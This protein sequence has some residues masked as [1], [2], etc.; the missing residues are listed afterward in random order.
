IDQCASPGNPR[1]GAYV[2][3][4]EDGATGQLLGHVGFSPLG[5]EVEVSYAIAEY[6]RGRGYGSEALGNACR[7]VAG[8]FAVDEIIAITATANTASRRTLARASFVH[9]KDEV[10]RFQGTEQPVSR[11]VWRA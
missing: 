7:W 4:V 5:G 10:M 8:T 9:A 1:L 11:Y 6:A 3:G 2:L